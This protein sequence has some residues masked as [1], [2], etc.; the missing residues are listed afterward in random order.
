ML[1]IGCVSAHQEIIIG[2]IID[3]KGDGASY[4]QGIK[5][6][7]DL[8]IID[9]NE[10][11]AKS[12][13]D[14]SVTGKTAFTDGTREGAAQAAEDLIG[15]GAQII[16][17]PSSS[18][19]VAGIL[20]ILTREGM[21]SVNPSSSTVISLPGDPLVRLCPDDSQL[22]KA[23]LKYHQMIDQKQPSKKVVLL[24]RE[25]LYGEEISGMISSY[26]Q[27]AEPVLYS[28][29]TVDFST[30][31]KKLDSM[32]TPLTEEA[33]EE[34]VTIIVVSLDE[35]GDLLAQA[36]A[37]PGLWNA[38]WEGM[39][40]AALQTPVVENETAAE[41]AYKTGFTALSFNIAQPPASDYWRVFDVV[42]NAK[43]GNIP[44]IYEILPYDE[45]LMAAWIVQGSPNNTDDM[46]Y[47]ADNYGKYSYAATGWLKLNENSDREYGDY[48]F[49]T[50]D[51][52]D[53]G[54]YFWKPTFVYSFENDFIFTLQGVNNT[55][56][57]R[58]TLM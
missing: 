31:L 39:D 53:D 26:E 30:T 34:N 21:V 11:Y 35:I 18:E 7:I 47:I 50:V 36:S 33:G 46:L 13:I 43:G 32:V 10:S 42:S 14:T 40:G 57:Q 8:A 45:T 38:R 3:E 2:A 48:Y 9:L 56:M 29:H 58:F 20:P 41:F 27:V 1:C 15:Q 17:G 16:V 19:E 28:P 51:K 44:S 49:Y 52:S 55:F 12:G 4:A 24:A 22:M 6:A 23:V 25:D 37:Y 5:A 54:R